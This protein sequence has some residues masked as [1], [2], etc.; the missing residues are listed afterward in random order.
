MVTATAGISKVPLAN[1]A[2]LSAQVAYI[3]VPVIL[4]TSSNL[5]LSKI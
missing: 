1:H 2:K 4:N 3:I 5:V